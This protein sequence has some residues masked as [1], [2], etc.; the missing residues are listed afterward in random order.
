MDYQQIGTDAVSFNTTVT[1]IN[2]R[3]L[4][5]TSRKIARIIDQ[6]KS[7]DDKIELNIDCP[8]PEDVFKLF[9][10]MSFQGQPLFK[11][12]NVFKVLCAADYFENYELKQKAMEYARKSVEPQ[13]IVE[14]FNHYIK[15]KW[16]WL[17]PF[18][19]LFALDISKF[20]QRQDFSLIDIN[21][22]VRILHRS[23]IQKIPPE[24]ITKFAITEIERYK[25]PDAVKLI[26]FASLDERN[27]RKISELLSS[28]GFKGHAYMVYSILKM[29][30]S[31]QTDNIPPQLLIKK[32]FKFNYFDGIFAG[33]KE[34]TG[35]K[36]LILDG[37][38]SFNSSSND[39][40]SIAEPVANK[41]WSSTDRKNCSIIFKLQNA[42][43]VVTGYRIRSS[44]DNF[45]VG[46]RVEGSYNGGDSWYLIDEQKNCADIS[47]PHTTK[48][49]NIEAS[50]I[51]EFDMIRL[52]QTQPNSEGNHI[53]ALNHF[54][55]YGTL[56]Q[57]AEEEKFEIQEDMVYSNAILSSLHDRGRLMVTS[58]V[59][60]PHY[61]LEYFR[62]EPWESMESDENPAITFDFK[63]HRVSPV[64]Y[65]LRTG[66]YPID[67]G[68]PV[69]WDFLVGNTLD[70]LMV[71]HSV[72][73]NYTDLNAPHVFKYFQIPNPIGRLFRFVQIRMAGPNSIGTNIFC[74]DAVEL[75]GDLMTSMGE[76]KCM[77]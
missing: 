38:I 67:G 58:S 37:I 62:C 25:R 19:E 59:N 32:P 47:T 26:D 28:L 46:W 22:L 53:F 35:S 44:N 49:Y 20:I 55:I 69:S 10:E 45:P 12:H 61:L 9:S 50:Y 8:F 34:V 4:I 16:R 52:T 41:K 51:E 70:T 39:P 23:E 6:N 57:G 17:E 36:N 42:R 75:Y 3:P 77:K 1:Y 71:I 40:V 30:K 33:L 60:S 43:A 15:I 68:H 5:A 72:R 66:N 56:Y 54:D 73:D 18:Y 65:L 2:A 27:I 74:L 14:V 64:G 21:H 11:I 48:I 29:R 31:V 13:Y 76:E 7:E 24:V 63:T